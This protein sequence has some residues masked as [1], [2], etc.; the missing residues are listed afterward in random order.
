MALAG[1]VVAAKNPAINN[2]DN[3]IESFMLF[4]PY[5]RLQMIREPS[6]LRRGPPKA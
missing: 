5:R 3:A 4:S 6:A 1:F 2:A